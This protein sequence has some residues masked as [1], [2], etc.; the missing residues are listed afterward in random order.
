LDPV[1]IVVTKQQASARSSHARGALWRR[2]VGVH[3]LLACAL[4]AGAARPESLA[5]IDRFLQATRKFED[6]RA[7][8][9]QATPQAQAAFQQLLA[10]DPNNPLYLAYYGSTLAL[11][12]RDSHLPWQRINLVR[13]SIGTLDKAL[14]LLQP[15]DDRRLLRDIP[16][17][18]ETRLIAIATFV[19]LPEVL[20]KLPAAKQQL[21]LAMDSPAFASS[22]AELRGRFYYELA[23]VAA[24]EGQTDTERTALRQVLQNAPASLDLDEVR[25][26]LAKL[27]SAGG[28]AAAPDG[29]SSR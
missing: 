10:V 16:V 29:R 22:P 20:H 25:A 17:S 7:G 4:W 9:T 11:Q 6:A 18:L 3:L 27:D 5:P 14:G 2:F 8:S 23:L 13:E 21:T 12:A 28:A 1:T 24:A 26:R 19:A 15:A